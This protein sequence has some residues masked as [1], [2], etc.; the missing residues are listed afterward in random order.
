M[1]ANNGLAFLWDS[2]C[3]M[4]LLVLLAATAVA[5][6]VAPWRGNCAHGFN[7]WADGFPQLAQVVHGPDG[8]TKRIE[9][10]DA[11]AGCAHFA[12]G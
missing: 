11:D 3:P 10:G 5:Q 4:T 9:P 1:T 6:V 12:Q 8:F 2:P 7:P